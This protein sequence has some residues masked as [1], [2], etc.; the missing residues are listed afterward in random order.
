MTAEQSPR[1]PPASSIPLALADLRDMLE[2]VAQV[3]EWT[4]DAAPYDAETDSAVTAA[5]IV[6]RQRL[7]H[8][9]AAFHDGLQLGYVRFATIDGPQFWNASIRAFQEWKSP[10]ALCTQVEAEEIMDSETRANETRHLN[11]QRGPRGW[12][13]FEPKNEE[14]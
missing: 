14:A 7:A 11:N 10:G 2:D 1:R 5:Q 9:A 6:L 12:T 8:H 13:A 3:L 4:L